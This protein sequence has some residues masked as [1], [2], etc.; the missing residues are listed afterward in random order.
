MR[1]RVK[2]CGITRPE[3]ALAAA[4]LGADAIGL[5]F[6]PPSPR[7]ITPERAVSIVEVL[8][9]FITVV[10]LFVNES[11]ER[12]FQVMSKVKLDVIQFHGDELPQECAGFGCPYI[13]AVRMRP[14]TDIVRIRDGYPQASGL[15]LDTYRKGTPG[16]TGAVFDWDR[17]PPS[18][19]KHVILAGGL[20]PENIE[21]AILRVNPYAVDVSGGVEAEKGVKDHDKIAALMRGVERANK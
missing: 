7:A 13:K 17:V 18:I 8:P 16:G 21:R 11:R 2:I 10:G 1:T 6:F 15:L 5:V 9:P 3:D 4:K 14:E 19:A 12:I 20:S